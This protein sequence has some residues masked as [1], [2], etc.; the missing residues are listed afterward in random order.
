MINAEKQKGRAL[1][2]VVKGGP[3]NNSLFPLRTEWEGAS[4]AKVWG[5]GIEGSTN[6]KIKGPGGGN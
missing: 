3:N 2:P 1:V 4:H 5:Q 6:S